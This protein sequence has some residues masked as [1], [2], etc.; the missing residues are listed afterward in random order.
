MRD[1]DEQYTNRLALAALMCA[2]V[3]LSAEEL[4]GAVREG[5]A[6]ARGVD[7]SDIAG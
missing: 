5:V 3:S 7:G 1:E 6:D 4:E 2:S